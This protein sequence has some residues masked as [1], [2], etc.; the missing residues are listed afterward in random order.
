MSKSLYLDYEFNQTAEEKVNLVCCCTYDPISDESKQFWLHKSQEAKEEFKKYLLEFTRF[1]A[2][3]VVA[4]ARSFYSMDI[5]PLSVE[6]IDLYL[7]YKC[8]S[9]HNDS[10]AYGKQLINGRVVTV[11]KNIPEWM[12]KKED[13]FET[14]AEEES[15]SEFTQTGFKQTHS[16]AEATYKLTGEIRDTEEKDR[17]RDLI[18]SAPAEFTEEEKRL[19]LDYCTEDV[20]HLPEIEKEINERFQELL[21]DS[22]NQ[23]EL[24]TEQLWR[25]RY[26]AHTSIMESKGYPI[27]YEKLKRFS[28]QVENIL[29]DCQREINELF[30]EI[31]PFRWNKKD[32]RFS[33]NQT[34]TKAWIS[35]NHDMATWDKT[36]KDGISLSLDAWTKH[37]DFKH[38]YPKDNFGAQI[39]RYLKLQQSLNGFRPSPDKKKRT[40]WNS[41]GSDKRVR[42]YMG[43]YGAQSGRSQ[44]SSTGF[45]FLKPAWMRSL[46][47]PAKGK[48]LAGID[49]GSQEFFISALLSEDRNMINA[50]LSGDVYLA[51]AKIAGI[52]PKDG[53]R[54]D[55]EFE[56]NFCKSTVLGISF[57]MTKYGLSRKLTVDTG[58][59]WTIDEA[60]EQIDKF[61]GAFRGLSIYQEEIEEYYQDHGIIKLPD[62]WTMWGDNPNFRSVANVPIQGF[63]SCVMRKAVDLSVARGLYIPFTLHDALYIEGNIGEEY[64]I[65]ILA[66][67]MREAFAF[68]FLNPEMRELAKN[69]KLDAT[70]WSPDYQPDS[71]MNIEGLKVYCSNIYKDKRALDEYEQFSKYFEP[72]DWDLL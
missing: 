16:L 43:I 67:Q 41:V 21:G 23:S 39:V 63:G 42:P 50:S 10:I 55:Y 52:V 25:G 29:Y 32:Q 3:A 6:W 30:P 24:E 47:V 20:I 8:L 4:E 5:D 70:A 17:I 18:I 12:K 2:Y 11:K 19:I 58:K 45:M 7:E 71:E 35:K 62:G 48:F 27:D 33:W 54:S 26:S 37:Y 49:Y 15:E 1:K 14:D 40:F 46:V 69:I 28:T 34:A 13:F 36:D 66:D 59:P 53:K 51:F 68:Y 56:R 60:Q 64:K 44:P 65:K 31:L 22:F 9:N 72:Q 57:L 38:S 61:Y